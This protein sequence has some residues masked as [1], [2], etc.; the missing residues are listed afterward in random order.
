MSADSFRVPNSIEFAQELQ[1][2]ML[3][4]PFDLRIERAEAALGMLGVAEEIGHTF[5]MESRIGFLRAPRLSGGKP[6]LL[7]FTDPITV[8]GTLDTFSYFSVGRLDNLPINSLCVSLN[9][10]R[11]YPDKETV[12]PEAVLHVPA[13]AVGIYMQTA[14]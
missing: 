4:L 2:D 10:L 3:D 9:R 14:A 6:Y 8:E 11:F 13:L 5:L 7:K 1:M 12:D